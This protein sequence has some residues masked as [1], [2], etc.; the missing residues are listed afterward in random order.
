MKVDITVG[1]FWFFLAAIFIAFQG[2]PDLID[3]IIHRLYNPP[4]CQ[5]VT[6]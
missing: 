2:E 3:A 4:Q 5:K 6:P 1:M